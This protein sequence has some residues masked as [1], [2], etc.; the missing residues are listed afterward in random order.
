MPEHRYKKS[1]SLLNVTVK[2]RK[3]G[4]TKKQETKDLNSANDTFEHLRGQGVQTIDQH[5]LH[6]SK[7]N[8]AQAMA[9]RSLLKYLRE[10]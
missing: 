3:T 2:D 5:T 8:K 4:K 6:A 10:K 7:K 9:R 1:G